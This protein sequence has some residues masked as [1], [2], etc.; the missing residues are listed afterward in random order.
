MQ[1]SCASRPTGSCCRQRDLAQEICASSHTE[2]ILTDILHKRSSYTDPAQVLLQDSAEEILNTLRKR[3]SYRDFAQEVI[4]DPDAKILTRRSCARDPHTEILYMWSH[5]G[6][7]MLEKEI[8]DK[9]LHTE[10]LHK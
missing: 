6:A 5:L 2:Q 3:S 1:R 9:D 4:Q 10:I 7:E 8:L